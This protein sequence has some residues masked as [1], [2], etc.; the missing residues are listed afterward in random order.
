MLTL[1]ARDTCTDIAHYYLGGVYMGVT[2]TAANE[3]RAVALTCGIIWPSNLAAKSHQV[4]PTI[5]LS[6][7]SDVPAPSRS[8]R[9]LSIYRSMRQCERVGPGPLNT[10]RTRRRQRAVTAL[11]CPGST[12][13]TS[14]VGRHHSVRHR[15]SA[16]AAMRP[17]TITTNTIRYQQLYG[18]ELKN[19]RNPMAGSRA[20]PRR[21]RNRHIFV[22]ASGF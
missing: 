4:S 5:S 13:A 12:L 1:R 16:M 19:G 20:R 18:H 17:V 21:H 7:A 9:S 3:P 22:V 2:A 15:R 8:R 10:C 6:P 14:V 11:V